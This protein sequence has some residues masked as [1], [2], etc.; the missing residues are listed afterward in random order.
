MLNHGGETM[1]HL[2]QTAA[3]LK[4]RSLDAIWVTSSENR[5]Y[6]T[7]FSSSAGDVVICADGAG[8]LFVDFRYI[9]AAKRAAQNT[10]FSVTMIPSASDAVHY[11]EDFCQSKHIAT[12]ATEMDSMPASTYTYYASMFSHIRLVSQGGLLENLRRCKDPEEIACLSKAQ[13]I[14]EYALSQTLPV[15]HPGMTEREVGAKLIY[16]ILEAGGELPIL[17]LIVVAGKNSSLPHGEPSSNEIKVGDFLT[18]DFTAKYQGYSSDMTR[19]FAIGEVNPHMKEVYQIVLDAQEAAI[20]ALRPGATGREV[21]AVARDIISAAGYGRYFQHGLGHSI[22]LRIHES[23]RASQTSEDIFRIGDVITIEPG[24]YL[25]GQFGVRIEDMLWIS[26]DG[27][28]NL[29]HTPKALT[30][31]K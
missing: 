21:D 20:R 26:P 17:G 19:T 3:A 28:I 8:V 31:L 24:I 4:E 10:G 16:H 18:I 30:V 15:I 22:G 7:G 23:P 6:V 27:V 12:L 11:I 29:T 9:E 1:Q 14:A 2:Q 13:G 25:P 5:R